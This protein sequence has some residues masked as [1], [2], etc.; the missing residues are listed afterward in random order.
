M[1]PADA[2]NVDAPF[3]FGQHEWVQLLAAD[4]RVTARLVFEIDLL[5][6]DERAEDH[7]VPSVPERVQPAQLLEKDVWIVIRRED[8]FNLVASV[9]VAPAH[10]DV[11]LAVAR[12]DQRDLRHRSDGGHGVGMARHQLALGHASRTVREIDVRETPGPGDLHAA[13][14]LVLRRAERLAAAHVPDVLPG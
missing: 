2:S 10:E 14:Y 13:L 9:L 6:I 4:R 3:L 7:H 11:L 5:A 8:P 12:H 1:R